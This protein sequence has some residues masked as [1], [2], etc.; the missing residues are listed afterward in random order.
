MTIL[1]H[2]EGLLLDNISSD[3]LLHVTDQIGLSTLRLDICAA[4]VLRIGHR[5]ISYNQFAL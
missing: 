1:D 3:P 2:I 5:H 4:Q